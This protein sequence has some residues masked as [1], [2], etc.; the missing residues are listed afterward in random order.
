MVI[1]VIGN[2]LATLSILPLSYFAGLLVIDIMDYHECKTHKRVEAVFASIYGLSS[3][4]GGGLASG[5]VG[6]IMG[7]SGFD[8]MAATQTDSAL[9]TIVALYG[10]VPAILMGITAV[11][12]FFFDLEKKLPQMKAEYQAEKEQQ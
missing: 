9:N 3:K 1:L 11:L 5:L 2:L 6:L 7:M 10:W 4:L 12:M 8:G